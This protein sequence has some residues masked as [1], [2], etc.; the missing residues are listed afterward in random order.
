L[1]RH[2]QANIRTFKKILKC[3]KLNLIFTVVSRIFFTLQ[4]TTGCITLKLLLLVKPKTSIN[5][6]T[7]K[8]KYLIAI[9]TITL[10]SNAL[11]KIL[12]QITRTLKSPLL[13]KQ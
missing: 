11:R 7:L 13:L 3:Y 1:Q 10:I 8:I 2:Y 12:F 5:I 4:H 6:R 9:L